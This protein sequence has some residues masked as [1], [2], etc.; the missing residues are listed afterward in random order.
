[1]YIPNKTARYGI[2]IAMMCD[3]GT[4]YMVNAIPYLGLNTQTKGVHL[5]SYFVK[6]L[7]KNIQGTNQNIIMDNW[8]TSIPLADK[9]LKIPINFTV[10]GTIWKNKGEIPP[11]LLELRSQRVG[12]SMYCFD[13][14]KTLIVQNKTN[15]LFY[16]HSMKN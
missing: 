14:A 11:E 13:Q 15:V 1:M 16:L 3:V 5:L 6:E 4:N 2:K 8:F 9:L 10:V 12:T 7:T